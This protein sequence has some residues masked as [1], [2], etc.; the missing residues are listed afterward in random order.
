M[1]LSNYLLHSVVGVLVFYGIGFDLFGRL[2]LPLALALGVAF[3]AVQIVASE[4]WL[5]RAAFGPAEWFW[6]MFT[7]G[8]RFP[9]FKP[10]V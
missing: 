4:A 6:R 3:F 7:Y 5:S 9:L 8:R 2:S 1:A 10:A